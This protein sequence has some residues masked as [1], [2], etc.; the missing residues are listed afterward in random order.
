MPCC[1]SGAKAKASR[2][3]GGGVAGGAWVRGANLCE[4]GESK[5][6]MEPRSAW[7]GEVGLL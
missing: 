3:S 2:G 7:G 4:A 5:R 6:G 1:R